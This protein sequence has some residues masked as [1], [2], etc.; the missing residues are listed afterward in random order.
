MST[1]LRSNRCGHNGRMKAVGSRILMLAVATTPVIFA[2]AQ[3]SG[4]KPAPNAEQVYKDIE[5]FRGVPASDIIPSMQFMSA[6]MNYK[7]AD[8][9]DPKDYAADNKNKDVTRKMIIMQREINEKNFENRLEVTCMTCHN[10]EE[11]PV[12]MP[13]PSGIE[14]R[15][16]AAVGALK[17]AELIANHSTAVGNMT[18]ALVRTGT[19]TAPNDET[20]KLETLPLELI[21]A[22]GGKYRIVSGTRKLTSDGKSTWYAE[23]PQTDEPAAIFNRM[24]RAW[25]PDDFKG[26]S[27]TIVTGQSKVSGMDTIV[28]QGYRG[29]TTSAEELYFDSKTSLLARMVNIKRS[30]LGTVVSAI[31]Y[32]DYQSVGSLKVPMKVVFTFA[33]G[34]Q[35]VM[36]F[37]SAKIDS[38]VKEDT[39]KVGK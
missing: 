12:G 3:Q 14:M 36:E 33:E 19:L 23:F 24:G 20:H 29:S 34:D 27:R 13:V 9:H 16:K 25:Q 8:C 2:V 35:W 1:Q 21:Q 4:D 17:P 11:H 39:F 7:C 22:P 31:D 32:S 10:K 30:T 38:S 28:I 6:S 37:K 18:D 5:V 26:L 15:H